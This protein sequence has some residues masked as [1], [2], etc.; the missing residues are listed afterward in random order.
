[1]KIIKYF[2]AIIVCVIIAVFVKNYDIDRFQV[3]LIKTINNNISVIVNIF[4]WS[5]YTFKFDF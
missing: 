3:L 4:N 1:M 2:V 5:N